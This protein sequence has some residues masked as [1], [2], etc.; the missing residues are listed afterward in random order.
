MIYSERRNKFHFDCGRESSEKFVVSME[1]VFAQLCKH[2]RDIKYSSPN[3]L[4]ANIIESKKQK[5]SKAVN[6]MRNF[7]PTMVTFWLFKEGRSLS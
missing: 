7:I 6:E 5:Q 1:I 4:L 2:S 3:N